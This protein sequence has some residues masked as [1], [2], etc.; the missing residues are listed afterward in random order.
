[1]RDGRSRIRAGGISTRSPWRRKTFSRGCS[2]TKC[3][4]SGSRRLGLAEH[5]VAAVAQREREELE[6]PPL[7]VG[8]K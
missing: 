7:E 2:S 8:V 4:G 5:E 1:M 6:G 3:S